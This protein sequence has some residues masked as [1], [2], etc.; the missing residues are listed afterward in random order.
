MSYWL[1]SIESVYRGGD[2]LKDT[3]FD[4]VV[5][6]CGISGAS[7]AYH[8][9]L[10]APHNK[11]AIVERGDVS[12]GAT[13]C[14]GGFIC[15]GTSEKFSVS[16]DRYGLEAAQAMYDYTVRCTE[17]VQAFVKD[18][19]VDCELRF[20]GCVELASSPEELAGLQ[21]SFEQLISFGQHVE[22]WDE[23]ICR[24]RTKSERFLGGLYN[25]RAG[26]LWAAKL[27]HALVAEGVKLGVQVITHCP[28]TQVVEQGEGE[29]HVHT[30]RGVLRA[31]RV[32]YA[33]NAWSRDLLPELQELIIPV[34]NQVTNIN[35]TQPPRVV[36]IISPLV[37]CTYLPMILCVADYDQADAADVGLQSGLQLRLRVLSTAARWTHSAG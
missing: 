35:S 19:S 3:L 27:V 2:E 25:P 23:S 7:A 1:S 11:V 15:P 20:H 13:G 26:M 5:I 22:W 30:A 18:H 34:R 8:L 10:N 24:E 32:V 33:A 36:L 9:A 29:L 37:A 16:V 17:L 31:R 14:N 4:T 21:K 28:V 12:S 6:G